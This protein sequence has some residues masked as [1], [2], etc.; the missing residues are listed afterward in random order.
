MRVDLIN[1]L[2]RSGSVY[3][4]LGRVT[5]GL[6]PFGSGHSESSRLNLILFKISHLETF[7]SFWIDRLRVI[8]GWV[9]SGHFGPN[10][11]RV[12]WLF[13]SLRSSFH[14]GLFRS[15]WVCD[16][17]RSRCSDSDLLW[18]SSI[19]VVYIGFEVGLF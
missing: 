9:V 18:V 10:W 12:F 3:V 17:V 15:G 19:Y 5:S 7:E 11:G 2:F 16:F 1:G 4:I 13:S 8:L 14:V 6:S